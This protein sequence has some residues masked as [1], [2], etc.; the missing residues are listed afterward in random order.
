MPPLDARGELS[1]LY[2]R[3]KTAEF[4]VSYDV[5]TSMSAGVTKMDQYLKGMSKIR[6]DTKSQG[7]DSRAYMLSDILYSCM[8]QGGAWKCYKMDVPLNMS[9]LASADFSKNLD[10]YTIVKDG[11]MSVAGTSAACYKLTEISTGHES[12][13]C[14]SA[15]GVPLYVK[16]TATNPSTGTFTSELTATNYGTSVPDSVFELPAVAETLPSFGGQMGG[17]V[18]PC[19]YCDYL[20][21]ADKADCLASCNQ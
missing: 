1:D 19:A 17:T 21:G 14:F 16:S 18:D 15:E 8:M 11:S 2:N 20:D 7:V 13:S 3:Q 4:L 9:E 10:T 5:T 6:I 12:R